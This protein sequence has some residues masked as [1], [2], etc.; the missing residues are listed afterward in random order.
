[1]PMSLVFGRSD[2]KI[3]MPNCELNFEASKNDEWCCN[4]SESDIRPTSLKE[5]LNFPPAGGLPVNISLFEPQ[6][7]QFH[8]KEEGKDTYLPFYW[9]TSGTL[10]VA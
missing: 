3:E 8:L 10:A 2:G 7:R 1:M 6:N 4:I 5:S 9:R